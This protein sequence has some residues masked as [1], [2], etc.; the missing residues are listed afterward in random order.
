MRLDE[1]LVTAAFYLDARDLKSTLERA[2][3]S[4]E[5]RVVARGESWGTSF[6]RFRR[7][8]LEGRVSF[9]RGA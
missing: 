8:N 6:R 4:D 3:H 7:T 1:A 9:P 2:K 5:A